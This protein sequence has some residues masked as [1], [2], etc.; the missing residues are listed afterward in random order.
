MASLNPADVPLPDNDV[1]QQAESVSGSS[2]ASS[3]TS[4]ASR[5]AMPG[6]SESSMDSGAEGGRSRETTVPAACLACQA[7]QVRRAEPVRALRGFAE[8]VHLCALTPRL[9]GPAP[10][11]CA[12]P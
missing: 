2:S 6:G 11:R 7:P 10:R 5:M 9:Q 8:R 4:S 1:F 12:E 3:V